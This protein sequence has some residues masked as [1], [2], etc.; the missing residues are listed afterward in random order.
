MRNRDS[1]PVMCVRHKSETHPGGTEN[2]F[3]SHFCL[4]IEF[5]FSNMKLRRGSS[6]II[7]R[8]VFSQ[9]HPIRKHKLMK[10]DL[11]QA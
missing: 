8:S 4:L 9:Q 5:L 11:L 2:A 1:Y 6:V 3:I 10:S 7:Q